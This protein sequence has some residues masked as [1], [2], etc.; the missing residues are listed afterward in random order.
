MTIARELK[1]AKGKPRPASYPAIFI[2]ADRCIECFTCEVACKEEHGLP[3]GPRLIRVIKMEKERG[4]RVT[5]VSAPIAC[6]HCSNAPCIASCPSK[7]ITRREDLGVVLVNRE[8]CIGCKMCLVACPFGVPQFD[9]E[10]RMVKCDLCVGRLEAGL[11]PA[12][13][14][15][16]PV[17][18]IKFDKAERVSAPVRGRVLERTWILRGEKP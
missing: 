1:K 3:V 18:A 15:A 8:R 10:G 6:S 12:C 14:S 13:A 9:A 5:R 11:K 4:G 16:C 2:D 17:E 7:A